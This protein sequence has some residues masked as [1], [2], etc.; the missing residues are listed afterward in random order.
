MNMGNCADL[1]NGLHLSVD[2]ISWT[3]A[4]TET[5]DDAILMMGF[6]PEDFKIQPRGLNGY[7]SQMRHVSHS[8]SVQFD[9]NKNMGIHIDVSGS[10]VYALLTQFY[11]SHLKRTVFGT[12]GFETDSFESTVLRELMKEIKQY[13][14]I[15]RLDLA[16]D[17]IGTNYYSLPE[18]HD[19]FESG[20]YVSRFRSWKE[21]LEHGKF[22][23][24]TIYLGSRTSSA[25]LRIYDKQAEQNKKLISADMPPVEYSWV[26]WELELKRE[27]AQSVLELVINGHDIAYLTMGILANYLSIIENDCSRKERCSIAKKYQEF[28]NN[29]GKISLYSSPSEKT[30][31]DTKKWLVRQV[32]PSLAKIA[33]ADGG[34]IDFL[35]Y[36]IDNGLNRLTDSQL[37]M[38]RVQSGGNKNDTSRC[39]E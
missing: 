7:R 10:A 14:H 13:G 21:T 30:I 6:E 20:L 31:D 33:L 28:I 29:I 16:V 3:L 11:E 37:E 34:C 18:L 23:G 26:R 38:I 9:G 36:L 15:T 24:H 19:L 8:I 27:R 5:V 12:D 35:H 4:E 2:W 1:S 25:M 22:P 39:I 32:A 17:D